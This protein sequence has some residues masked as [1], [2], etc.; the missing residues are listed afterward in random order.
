MRIGLVALLAATLLSTGCATYLR[1]STEVYDGPVPPDP[2]PAS[3][4]RMGAIAENAVSDYGTR[5]ADTAADN[6][7]QVIA[8]LQAEFATG[9]HPPFGNASSL[10]GFRESFRIAADEALVPARRSAEA[11]RAVAQQLQSFACPPAP[12]PADKDRPHAPANAC[13]PEVADDLLIEQYLVTLRNSLTE[14]ARLGRV[15]IEQINNEEV[16]LYR[17]LITR[18]FDTARNGE[19]PKDA[20]LAQRTG[21]AQIRDAADRHAATMAVIATVD[22]ITKNLRAADDRLLES[23]L[24][25][26]PLNAKQI[27]VKTE[28]VPLHDPAIRMI[29]AQPEEANVWKKYVNDVE[30]F[31]QFGNAEIAFRMDGLGDSHIKGVLFDSS[32]AMKTGFSVL[33][34]TVEATATAFGGANFAPS[35]TADPK[36]AIGGASAVEGA[37]DPAAQLTSKPA[38]DAEVARL[39]SASAMRRETMESLFWQL[40]ALGKSLP[41]EGAAADQAKKLIALLECAQNEIADPKGRRCGGE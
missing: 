21:R 32:Q 31:N 16:A 15:A 19:F 41:A 11:T 26:Q 20:E 1:V 10:S 36:D 39:G 7:V 18:N 22:A 27:L 3:A 40:T 6:F 25:S 4:A 35:K 34:K 37:T 23:L 28:M 33:A 38:I 30:S 24:V 17:S 2:L 12:T 13:P 8:K 9:E 5:A 29:L 14:T